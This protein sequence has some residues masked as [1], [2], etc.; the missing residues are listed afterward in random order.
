VIFYYNIFNTVVFVQ[1]HLLHSC[2]A[3]GPL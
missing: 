3:T 1:V 2:H